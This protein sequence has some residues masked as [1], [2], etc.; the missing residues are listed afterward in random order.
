MRGWGSSEID[1][2][3]IGGV[4]L[5]LLPLYNRALC[6]RRRAKNTLGVLN[7]PLKSSNVL[8][9]GEHPNDKLYPSHIQPD[10]HGRRADSRCALDERQRCAD[11]RRSL[12][13]RSHLQHMT[14]PTRFRPL[15][16]S[17]SQYPQ[18][19]LQIFHVKVVIPKVGTEEP[20]ADC[21]HRLFCEQKSPPSI[22]AARL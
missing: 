19:E 1:F 9:Q 4:L 14:L 10:T 20:N 8:T 18:P 2:K 21:L 3:K 22:P 12:L 13:G 6:D 5:L 7:G 11:S 16:T 15:P 17:W